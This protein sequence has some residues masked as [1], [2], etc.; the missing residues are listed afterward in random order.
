MK[1]ELF[2]I[3]FLYYGVKGYGFMLMIG[4]L[5]AVWWAT[6]RAAKVR[7]NPDI[8]LNL[9][10][11]ALIFGVVGARFFY[12]VHYW[13]RN[14]AG[15]GLSAVL[16]VTAGGLEFYGGFIGAM[17]FIL[18]YVASHGRPL[19]ARGLALAWT[20]TT[21]LALAAVYVF[22]GPKATMSYVLGAV[23]VVVG[24]YIVRALWRW[25]RDAG[26]GA[27]ASF[28]LYADIIAP[29]L[30]WG[31]AFGRIGCFLNGCCWGAT[32][33]HPKLPWAVRFPCGSPVQLDQW[34]RGLVSLPAA[35]VEIHPA[36]GIG[37]PIPRELLTMS[38]KKYERH[39]R[40]Y[41]RAA[42]KLAE[43]ERS[44]DDPARIERLREVVEQYRK[45]RNEW[46]NSQQPVRECMRLHDLKSLGDL[47]E[48]A[49]REDCKS[50]PVHPAQLYSSINA[51][52]LAFVLNAI[53][54]RRKRHGV[55]FGLMWVLYPIARIVEEA[56]RA[57]NPLDTGGLTISQAV[58][59]GG[60]IFAL[61]WFWWLY[62][63][64]LRSPRAVAVE[65]AVR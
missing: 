49:R 6:R 16:D 42:A 52:L 15:R 65:S 63:Q 60:L 33:T 34:R 47:Q 28:R 53:F 25:A 19:I 22:I 12:V 2:D 27:P 17:V 59:V 4:F 7:M 48:L 14:F 3:P 35:L 20:V 46:Y 56:I 38:M 51:F 29:S 30:L 21:G 10:F 43:A 26:R 31:L 36:T 5:T 61:V 32:C 23:L 64:P 55:V 11:I 54:Y 40:R 41:Q 8:V 13:E 39:E 24:F 44:H 62:R 57:D 50:L 58:S 45:I 1:P 18:W 37:Q 9:A